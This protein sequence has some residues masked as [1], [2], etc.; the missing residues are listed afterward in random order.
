MLGTKAFPA[1]RDTAR[2]NFQIMADKPGTRKFG[3]L[4]MCDSYVGLDKEAIFE[5]KVEAMPE[6]LKVDT[7]TLDYGIE[8]PIEEPPSMWGYF[9]QYLDWIVSFAFLYFRFRK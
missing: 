8:E 4:A 2:V 9:L 3:V 6:E 5:I 7:T 1:L